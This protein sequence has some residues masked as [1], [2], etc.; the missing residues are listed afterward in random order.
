M[1]QV[2]CFWS[3]L[4]GGGEGEGVFMLSTVINISFSMKLSTDAAG[5]LPR[6]S[7]KW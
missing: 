1:F 7:E 5:P 6:Y 4:G 2:V 3:L